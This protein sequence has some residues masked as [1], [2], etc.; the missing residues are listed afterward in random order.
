MIYTSYHLDIFPSTIH[1]TRVKDLQCVNPRLK[2]RKTF[3]EWDKI[4]MGL[5]AD[6]VG[7]EQEGV[8]LGDFY[9]IYGSNQLLMTQDS[10]LGVRLSRDI[11]VSAIGQ[12][13][14]TVLLSSSLHGIENLLQL[15]I[16]YCRKAN[17]KL[18]SEKTV[19]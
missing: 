5:I 3:V 18:C 15:S 7:V 16:S 13:D 11:V 12:A 17:V 1:W 4:V 14:D 2:H 6:Q 10:H 9:K 19:L 8:H